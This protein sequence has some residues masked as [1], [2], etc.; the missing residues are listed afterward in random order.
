MAATG[1]DKYDPMRSQVSGETL[2]DFL[3]QPI[4]ESI[5]DVPGI[6]P[7][8]AKKLAK[9]G[10]TT[11]HQLIGKFLSFK[12]KDVSVQEHC[13]AFWDFLNETGI[14]SHRSGVVQ[15]V[16]ERVNILIPGT[17]VEGDDDEE[18]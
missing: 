2:A 4:T 7:A 17:Y 3:R 10:I 11:C 13:D 8:A 12:G 15:A 5:T 14:S 16:A 6:C 1:G 18:Y 9:V